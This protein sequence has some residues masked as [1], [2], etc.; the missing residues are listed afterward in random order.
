MSCSFRAKSADTSG[1]RKG[2]LAR[3]PYTATEE[4]AAALVR[5]CRPPPSAVVPMGARGYLAAQLVDSGRMT[6]SPSSGG[7]FIVGPGDGIRQGARVPL[8]GEQVISVP[9]AELTSVRVNHQTRFQFGETEVVIE[10]GSRVTVDGREHD[11]DPSDRGLL[12]PA[13]AL[14][15]GTLVLAC[16]APGGT[17]TLEFASGARIEVPADQNHEA[18]QVNGPG[19]RLIVCEPGGNNLSVWE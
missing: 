14:Y 16:A 1:T 11:L 7:P 4:A 18:W 9:E 13:L 19:K 17:L 6:P 8:H 12:G 5:I 15:P 2:S 3:S 10:S